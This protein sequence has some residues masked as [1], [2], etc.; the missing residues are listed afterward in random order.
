MA[1]GLNLTTV[2]EGVETQEQLLLLG[3]YGCNRM[4]GYL[5]GRPVPPAQFQVWLEQPEFRWR[6]A[7]PFQKIA[8]TPDGLATGPGK[9]SEG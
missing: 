8:R 2:A 1:H 6:G 7:S 4:Q 3:S 5:F 9:G